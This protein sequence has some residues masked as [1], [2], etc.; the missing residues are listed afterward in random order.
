M[1]TMVRW[2]GYF[3]WISIQ[4]NIE[5]PSRKLLQLCRSLIQNWPLQ[6]KKILCLMLRTICIHKPP[7][8]HNCNSALQCSLP[9]VIHANSRYG[10]SFWRGLKIRSSIKWKVL[11][12][13]TVKFVSSRLFSA[14]DRSRWFLFN[15]GRNRTANYGRLYVYYS[16]CQDVPINKFMLRCFNSVKQNL[17][18]WCIMGGNFSSF[19]RGN[20]S[21]MLY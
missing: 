5:T 1:A 9:L 3:S 7:T 17:R 15:R 19:L 12:Y 4:F 21:M 6:S 13:Y 16:L 11:N 14:Q 18:L 8:D 10:S 2:S 20:S